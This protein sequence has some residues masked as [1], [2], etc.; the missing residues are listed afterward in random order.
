M[1][2]ED[3]SLE[4]AQGA[5]VELSTYFNYATE[6]CVGYCFA[7]G[8]GDKFLDGGNLN[9]I[10]QEI[11]VILNY[12]DK[13]EGKQEL[14]LDQKAFYAYLYSVY[15]TAANLVKGSCGPDLPTCA[16]GDKDCELWRKHYTHAPYDACVADIGQRIMLGEF[17]IPYVE[18]IP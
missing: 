17:R 6:N 10:M 18:Q 5:W 7:V 2:I 13:L 3:P 11:K 4:E 16:S 9:I 1:S 14:T 12:Y 8:T 15:A